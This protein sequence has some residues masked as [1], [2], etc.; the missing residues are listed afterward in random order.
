MKKKR[1]GPLS[2]CSTL[3][4]DF[5]VVENGEKRRVSNQRQGTGFK[6]Q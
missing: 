3:P 5:F 1:S 4:L 6:Q 2:S